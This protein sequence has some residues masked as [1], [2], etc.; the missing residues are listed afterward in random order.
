MF[1][2]RLAILCAA[3]VTLV[4]S[5]AFA[6][7]KIGQMPTARLLSRFGLERA[8]W[9]QATMDTRRDYV[10]YMTLDEDNIYVQSTGGIIT[11]FDNE[12]GRKRWARQLGRQ[13]DPSFAATSNDELVLVIAGI[14]M[15]ALNK[16]DGEQLWVLRL[17][18]PASTSPTMDEKQVYYGTIDGSVYAYDLKTIRELHNERKLPQYSA[19]AQNW[20]YKSAKEVSSRPVSNGRILHFASLDN[21]LYTV[22]TLE[23]ELQWQFETNR[24]ISAPITEAD[25]LVYLATEDFNVFCV[26][27]DGGTMRWQFVTGL[28]IR[29]QPRI[30]NNDVYVFPARGGMYSL[31]KA[32]G[33]RKWWRPNMVDYV[34]ATRKLVFVTDGLNNLVAMSRADGAIVGALP[35]RGFTVRFANE[36]TDRLYLATNSGLTVCIREQGIE[37]PTYHKFPERQPILPEFAPDEAEIDP[38]GADDAAPAG[39]AADDDSGV[40]F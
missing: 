31:R 36:L 26:S 15:Y 35:L 34:G 17:P 29:K 9:S 25:G 14:R 28:P 22:T 20:R 21:S 13:D 10:R 1:R 8:W 32:T 33:T 16:L 24:P 23:R 19:V 6:Q 38:A 11:A 37:F 5:Q 4:A 18:N 40:S 39:A 12:N 7:S 27:Q 2:H 3:A 30:V